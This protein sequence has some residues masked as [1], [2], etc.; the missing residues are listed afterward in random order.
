MLTAPDVLCPGQPTGWPTSGY[1]VDAVGGWQSTPSCLEKRWSPEPIAQLSTETIY[2]AIYDPD[3]PLTR[4][5]KRR[6][7]RRV[8]G[9]ERRGRLTAMTMISERPPVVEDRIEL[10]HTGKATASSAPGA[11]RRSARSSSEAPAS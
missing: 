3:V 6:R 9:L 11:G 8:Q 4:P 5:A 1:H 2:Q 7:R 10:G